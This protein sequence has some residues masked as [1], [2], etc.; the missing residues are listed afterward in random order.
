MTV[1]IGFEIALERTFDQDRPRYF[2]AGDDD[3]INPK[4]TIIYIAS[5]VNLFPIFY[6]KE[7]IFFF[8]I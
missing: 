8:K 2:P 6:F 5:F 1:N 7:G 3:V 4:T